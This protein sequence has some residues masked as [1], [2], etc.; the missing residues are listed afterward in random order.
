MAGVMACVDAADNLRGEPNA[1]SIG[2]GLLKPGGI[3]DVTAPELV[4]LVEPDETA[5][6]LVDVGSGEELVDLLEEADGVGDSSEVWDVD[7]DICVPV[8]DEM[9]C[10]PDMCGGSCGNCPNSAPVCVFGQCKKCKPSCATKECG[11]D[12][13]GGSCG[14]C[15]AKFACSNG[16][17]KAPLC[18]GYEVLFTENFDSCSQGGFEVIDFQPSDYVTWWGVPGGPEGDG[19]CELYLGDPL[20]WSYDTG[21]SVHLKLVSSLLTLPA[22]ADWRVTFSLRMDAEPI[23]ADPDAAHYYPY[24]FDVLFLRV[25]DSSG[26]ELDTVFTSKPLLNSTGE[27]Y[28]SVAADLSS[29]SG[30]SVRFVFDFD[31]FDSTANDYV[32]V[33]LDDFVVDSVCPY[34]LDEEDCN[35]E[36]AC[37]IDQCLPLANVET[38]GTCILNALEGCCLDAPPEF[39]DDEDPCTDDT[40][41]DELGQCVYQPATEPGPDC[42][43]A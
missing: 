2:T 19:D 38:L 28:V 7:A 37:T 5:T 3:A 27:E 42:P 43:P 12:G 9:E 1:G 22:G 14:D 41:D 33:F 34:C 32:G 17:C 39:C 30:S 36:D 21:S 4:D 15:P 40:C 24:D 18:S 10:G 25:L 31:T 35:D 29:F 13:C 8:C 20:V 26:A 16:F 6:E 23:L 11:P